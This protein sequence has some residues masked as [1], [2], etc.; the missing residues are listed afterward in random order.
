MHKALFWLT[1]MT[2]FGSGAH[3]QESVPEFDAQNVRP[4][5]DSRRTLLTDDAGLAPSNTFLGKLVFGT[6]QDQLTFT[7]NRNGEERSILKNL[8]TADMIFAYTISQFRMGVD[9][10]VILQATSDVAPS[11]GGLGDLAIDLRGTILRPGD[12][13]QRQVGGALVVEWE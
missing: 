7:L 4:T 12:G 6:A 8:M 10:P 5:I 9:V 1:I 3:A 2:G 11:Q 13:R